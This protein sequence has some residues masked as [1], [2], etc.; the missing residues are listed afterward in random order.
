MMMME[1]TA[2]SHYKM[3]LVEV[4]EN[5]YIKNQNDKTPTKLDLEQK[6]PDDM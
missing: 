4:W 3:M 2:Q 6:N 5:I 1:V